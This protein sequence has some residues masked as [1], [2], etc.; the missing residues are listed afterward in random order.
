MWTVIPMTSKLYAMEAPD[1]DDIEDLHY[2]N[3]QG[4]RIREFL[5]TGVPVILVTDLDDLEAT[6]LSMD[7]EIVT[8]D[9]EPE[10]EE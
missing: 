7:I 9:D 6:G 4:D 2:D 8:S 5:Q 3:V 1:C 10:D